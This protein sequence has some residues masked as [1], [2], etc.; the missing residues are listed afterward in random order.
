[1]IEQPIEV[2]TLDKD[3]KSQTI[4]IGSKYADKKDKQPIKIK[5][6]PP[7]KGETVGHY[8]LADGNFRFCT[9]LNR[10]F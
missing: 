7:G 2:E 6:E 10:N 5:Y 3:G 9:G 1:M 8:S 4:T